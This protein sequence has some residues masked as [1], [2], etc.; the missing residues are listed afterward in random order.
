MDVNDWRALVTVLA[1]VSFLGI[2]GWAYSQRAK[3][4]F[5]EAAQIPFLEEPPQAEQQK[6]E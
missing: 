5:D 6:R 1:F 2:V 3:K 4:R